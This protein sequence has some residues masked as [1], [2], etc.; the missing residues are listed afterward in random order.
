ML[1]CV[2]ALSACTQVG[3]ESPDSLRTTS[4]HLQVQVFTHQADFA[5]TTG[6]RPVAFPP[7]AETA[8]PTKI[9]SSPDHSCTQALSGIAL[10][11][12]QELP[13]LVVRAPHSQEWICLIGPGWNVNNTNPRPRVP[14]IVGRGEDD[15]EL[16]FT[17]PVSAVGLELLTNHS[18]V[19]TVT[20][21]FADGSSQ[22]LTDD[23]L[24]T[25]ANAFEFIGFGSSTPIVA[26]SIDTT[27][28][29]VQN[30]GLARIW[31]APFPP[32]AESSGWVLT[33][34][35]ERSRL[36][37]TAALLSGG[38]VLVAGG[39]NVTA[40][41]YDPGTGSWTRTGDT[42]TTYRA[43][44]LTPL[45]DGRVLI[46]GGGTSELYDP[47]SG[48]WFSAGAMV[49]VRFHHTA[50]RLL[51]GRVLVVGGADGEHGGTA[52]ASAELYDPATGSWSATG[53]LGVARRFHAAV[54]VSGGKVLVM[55]GLDASGNLLT[56]AELYD[57][58]TG[59]WS[60]TGAMGVGRAWHSATPLGSG[61]VLV[62]GGAGIDQALG[63]SAELYDPETGSWSATGAMATP[64]RFHSATLL[65]GGK[66]LVAGGFHEYTGIVTSAE[67]YDPAGGTWSAAVSMN[68]ERYSHTATL[69][70][71]G[72]VLAV[73]GV[74][75]H[76]QATAELYG[77]GLSCDT[78]N[79]CSRGVIDFSSGAPVCVDSP[80]PANTECGTNQ[81]CD[82]H[83]ACVPS[84]R[85]AQVS[86]G[87]G[88]LS[89]DQ[90]CQELGFTGATTAN[91]Y[92]WGQCAGTQ[93]RCPGGWQ[94]DG[95]TCAN[96]CSAEAGD[97]AGVSFCGAPWGW[98]SVRE[99]L[100]DGSTTFTANEYWSCS[101]WNPGWTVRVRCFY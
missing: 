41:L 62:V 84:V 48:L 81:I 34:S 26:L 63:A 90:L 95:T 75:N 2:I 49:S 35:M 10:P 69:L 56:S 76:D 67:L 8:Y 3:E 96:W 9:V 51:D 99:R 65:P 89:G 74:S 30:E 94:G 82:G 1:C 70:P 24:G 88:T 20:L 5:S 92:W 59:S 93:D 68:V 22:T 58:A 79:P 40:E 71:D 32:P 60:A 44:G 50:T 72:R 16:T 57:P 97:C 31:T 61:R 23:V 28:G 15:Y 12:H 66:V 47:V 11:W 73:G 55:G 4:A 42:L 85:T 77:S 38:K 36:Q 33:G 37:H 19:E 100:G 17:R 43:H 52:L 91:G 78:G 25:A 45:K 18:A 54:L 27:G 83:G 21:T 80:L 39:F 86:C 101:G 13:G 14:T 7:S 6:A 98:G 64:R 29:D 87:R 53:P 46:C